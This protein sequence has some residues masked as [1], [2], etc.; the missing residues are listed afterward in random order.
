MP[1]WRCSPVDLACEEGVPGALDFG[2]F[3]RVLSPKTP[4][5]GGPPWVCPTDFVECEALG[6]GGCVTVYRLAVVPVR[7]V[8]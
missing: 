5:H 6:P 7:V 4:V 8:V 2:K 3:A 1:I